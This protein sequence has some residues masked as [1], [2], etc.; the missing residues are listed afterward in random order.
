ML[1]SDTAAELFGFGNPV[2]QTVTVDGTALTV[3]GVLGPVGVDLVDANEDDQALRADVS[4]AQRVLGG[5]A[6]ARCPTIYVQAR[7]GRDCSARPTR[8]SQ[9]CCSPCTASGPRRRRLHHRHPGVAAEA[10]NSTDETLTV[11]LAGIAAISLLVGGIGVM[12]IMLVSVTERIREIGLRKALGATPAA[13]RRQFLVE[14]SVL[15]LAGGVLGAAVGIAGAHVLPPLIVQPDRRVRAR[16]RRRRRGRA[17]DRARLRRLPRRPGRRGSPRSTRCAASNLHP[18][19]VESVVNRR[20]SVLALAAGVPVA[21]LLLAACGGGGDSSASAGAAAAAPSAAPSAG[22]GTNGPGGN[23]GLAASGG[24]RGGLREDAAGAGQLVADRGDVVGV[25][26]VHQ[27]RDGDAGRRGL[28]D[29]GRHARHRAI[30]TLTATTV[31][32]VSTSGSCTFDRAGGADGPRFPDGRRGRA[33]R[34]GS[35]AATERRPRAPR[36]RPARPGVGTSPPR[37]AP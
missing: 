32:V 19:T 24:D 11:L 27:D 6:D 35:P 2:G 1:G 9:A 14:A 37:S 31:R 23:R 33:P 29:R 34:A 21:L 20:P 26:A 30:D 28:R 13:I 17:R 22:G 36:G 15:G 7:V 4:T 3:I 25:D 18:S 5:A 10:A 8:R 12:N 16:G